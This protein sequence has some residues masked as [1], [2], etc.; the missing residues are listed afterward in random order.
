MKKFIIITGFVFVLLG[1]SASVVAA[2][3]VNNNSNNGKGNSEV[4][5]QDHPEPPAV[6]P[7]GDELPFSN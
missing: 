2:D 3:A 7:H 4:A 6:N 1:S 5:Q